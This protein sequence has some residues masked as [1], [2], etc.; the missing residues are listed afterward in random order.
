M[1]AGADGHLYFA[2]GGRRIDSHL[3]R[4]RYIGSD[5]KDRQAIVDTEAQELRA[6]RQRLEKYHAEPSPEALALA[7]DNLDHPDRFVRYAARI[8]L[9]HQRRNNDDRKDHQC[10]GISHFHIIELCEG[11]HGC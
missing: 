11:H 9:E 7:W 1:I 4:L 2:T 3:F 6:L 8:A 10:Y 5:T